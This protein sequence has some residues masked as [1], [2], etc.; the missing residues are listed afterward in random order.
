MEILVDHSL[1]IP[2]DAVLSV[3]CG[4]TRRQAPMETICSHPLKFPLGLGC[5]QVLPVLRPRM[6]RLPRAKVGTS[7][8][9][10][11]KYVQSLLHAVIQAKPTDPY[12]YMIEQL[13]AA[14]S[15]R[16]T[17]ADIV[18]RPG[19]AVG[20]R[21]FPASASTAEQVKPV[22]PSKPPPNSSPPGRPRPPERELVH[23]E[24]EPRP[25]PTETKKVE[26]PKVAPAA[27]PPPL[28]LVGLGGAPD[29][30]PA[31]SVDAMDQEMPA[32]DSLEQVRL[33]LKLRLEEAFRS[34]QLEEAVRKAIDPEELSEEPCQPEVP[35]VEAPDEEAFEV[36]LQLRA[37][38]AD[39]VEHLG[40]ED[41]RF[42]E[43]LGNSAT[44]SGGAVCFAERRPGKAVAV[45]PLGLGGSVAR[46]TL[47]DVIHSW[48]EPRA[49]TMDPEEIKGKMRQ[50]LQDS[51][52]TGGDVGICMAKAVQMLEPEM[53][54]LLD[55][56]AL[57]R[58]GNPS[59]ELKLQER[60]ETQ[61]MLCHAVPRV[62][63][64]LD[65]RPLKAAEG[66]E[67]FG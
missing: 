51:V 31:P 62:A 33:Q 8:W 39:A 40:R 38:L 25:P 19:S 23:V 2:T 42:A 35:G 24:P 67:M 4:G 66:L 61:T 1:G 46:V 30:E 22:P 6:R 50:L 45:A 54:A 56:S 13:S 65:T 58:Q 59:E 26:E 32:D 3:R 36:K 60:Q 34:G 57:A 11:R 5:L 48:V 44:A 55:I 14:Q 16:P 15:K 52:S 47:R 9:A 27:D 28:P 64:S 43:N 10:T 63:P 53:I 12:A 17:L 20:A 49:P 18:S 7:V 21:R 29:V 41:Q 37:L